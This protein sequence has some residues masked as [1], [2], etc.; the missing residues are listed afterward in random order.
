[1]KT[2][3][4]LE[5]TIECQFDSF[6]KTVLRNYARDLYN[7]INRRN[8]TMVSLELA[9][10]AEL[11]TLAIFDKHDF[12]AISQIVHGQLV[13]IYDDV[14][15]DAIESLTLRQKDIILLS[16]FAEMSNAEIATL[17]ELSESTVHYHKKRA[18]AKLR[19][20]MKDEV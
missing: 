20:Y 18:L 12:D 5:E 2:K 14:I 16:Y 1:M 8:K 13:S 3:V 9:T 11:A 10:P 19:N 7:E 15:A 4:E 17:L 6:C